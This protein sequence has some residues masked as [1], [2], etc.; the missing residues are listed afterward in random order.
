[1][2]AFFAVVIVALV[3]FGLYYLYLNDFNP[4]TLDIVFPVVAAVLAASYF[5]GKSVWIDA[6]A[7]FRRAVPIAVFHEQTGGR[8]SGL[9][10]HRA[11]DSGDD[12]A[13]FRALK[14]FDTYAHYNAFKEL[15]VWPRLALVRSRDDDEARAPIAHLLE[16]AIFDWLARGENHVGYEPS[17][18][19]YALQGF[20][21]GGRPAD[22]L[23]PVPLQLA[24]E[25]NPFILASDARLPLP[26]GA[27][28]HRLAADDSDSHGLRIKTRHSE[29][30]LTL[31]QGPVHPFMDSKDEVGKRVRQNLLLEPKTPYAWVHYFILRFD[32]VQRASS[33]FASQAKKERVWAERLIEQLEKNF[34]WDRLRRYYEGGLGVARGANPQ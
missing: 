14:D 29:L 30:S 9:I 33:R 1:M 28:V 26:R 7:P 31:R 5:G 3:F 17:E 18:T 15:D 4:E 16:F 10:Q 11:G 8:V 23:A 2:V 32:F 12:M 13:R 20:G 6:P 24:M 25:P 27:S 19:I 34:S 21:G 22:D